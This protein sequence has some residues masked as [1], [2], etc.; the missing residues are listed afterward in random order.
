MTGNE[1]P[2]Q[3]RR[4]FVDQAAEQ[5][6]L[7]CI[8]R[9]RREEALKV[10]MRAY[11]GPI[12]AFA[13]R[14]LHHSEAA[15]DVRQ[16]VFLDAFRG[17][18]KFEGRSSLWSWLCGI[19]YHRCLDERRRTLRT[20]GADDLDGLDSL[21]GQSDPMMDADRIAAQRALE[22]C[23]GKLPQAMRAQVL[24]RYSLDL[25]YVEIGEIIDSPHGTV[26]VRISRLL[27]RLRRCLRGEGVG[28]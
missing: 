22:R 7:E 24:M 1:R 16:Q 18:D 21:V 2:P 20:D 4:S 19:A 25:S 28:R 23:L 27:P 13:R 17:L 8:R 11:G 14:M 5:E 26:Q 10:L 12:T 9:G 3:P 6:A 15:K